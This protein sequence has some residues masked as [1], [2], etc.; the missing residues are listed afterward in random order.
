MFHKLS[1][2]ILVMAICVNCVK[3]PISDRKQMNLIPESSIVS[4]SNDEYKKFISSNKVVQNTA[5]ALLVKKVGKKLAESATAFLKKNKASKRVAGFNWEF[6]LVNN[7]EKNAWCMPGGK[8]CF[9]TGIIPYTKDEVGMAVVMGHEIAHAI[10][11]HGNERMS[12]AAL[13][14]LGGI[15]LNVALTE[16]TQDARNLLMQAYGVSANVGLLLPFSRNHELEADQMGLVFMQLA[17]YDAKKA[18]DFW[19][20]ISTGG[21]SNLTF[22]S[23]HPSDQ[24]RIAAIETFLNSAKFYRYTH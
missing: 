1:G 10:A 2:L 17:G 3:V 18:V 19:K 5:D 9:Y 24:K 8:I 21:S 15:A 23:T 13:I 22:L 14:N 6:N 4:M 7:P 20:R 16:Q 11:R 12:E